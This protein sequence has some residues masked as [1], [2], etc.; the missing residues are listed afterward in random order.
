MKYVILI[1]ANPDPWGHPS[2][3]YTPPTPKEMKVSPP[4]VPVLMFVLLG[5]VGLAS[6]QQDWLGDPGLA[7]WSIVG[8]NAWTTSGTMMLFYLASLQSIPTDV[9]EAAAIDKAGPWRIFW[10]ITF[11]LL[12]PGHFFV[13]TVGVIGGLQLFD[14]ALIARLAG[15]AFAFNPST[16]LAAVLSSLLVGVVYKPWMREPKQDAPA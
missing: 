16:I 2:S 3:R 6:W 5:A 11:P 13:A 7:L 10:K 8:L 12:K 4:W 9:Y 14:Q 15:W 1:H